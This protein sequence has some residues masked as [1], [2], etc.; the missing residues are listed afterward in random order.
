[1]SLNIAL[2]FGQKDCYII[3]I[4]NCLMNHRCNK[5]LQIN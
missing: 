1:M 4:A 5:N 3:P 2:K